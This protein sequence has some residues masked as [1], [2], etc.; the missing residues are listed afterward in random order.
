MSTAGLP[1]T[2]SAAPGGP[3]WP[4]PGSPVLAESDR[5]MFARIGIGPEVTGAAGILRV[6]DTEAREVWGIRFGRTSDLGGLIFPYFDPESGCRVTCRLRRDHPEMDARGK[7]CEQ[8]SQPVW[9]QP[10]PV[11]PARRWPFAAEPGCTGRVR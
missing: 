3:R 5:Q 2:E 7:A 9:R 8:V 10:S 4:V 1:H 6:K 11:F